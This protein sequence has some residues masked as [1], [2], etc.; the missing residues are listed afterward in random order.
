MLNMSIGVP[1]AVVRVSTTEGMLSD[2]LP[3]AAS[4][5]LKVVRPYRHLL[6]SNL[7][8]ALR[9]YVNSCLRQA[10]VATAG[11]GDRVCGVPS[12]PRRRMP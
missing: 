1:G 12:G 5:A 2:I 3:T 8:R 6:G 7:S 11:P 9:G 10:R 4:S